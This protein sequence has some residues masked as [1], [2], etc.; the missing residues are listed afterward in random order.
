MG[1]LPGRTGTMRLDLDEFRQGWK[2]VVASFIGMA[3]SLMALAGTYSIGVLTGPLTREFGWS[4]GDVMLVPTLLY[5][6]LIPS[7]FVVGWI[8]DHYGVRKMTMFS[9]VALALGFAALGTL[10]QGGLTGF[11]AIYLLIGIFGEAAGPISYTRSIVGW[12]KRNRGFAL[13]LIMSG[14]GV[15]AI[16]IPAYTGWFVE[17]HGW[18]QAYLAL[19]VLPVCITLPAVWFLLKEVPGTAARRAGT[20]VPDPHGL[21]FTQ[22]IR[23]YRFWVM[24]AVFSVLTAI[25]ISVIT[26]LVPMLTDAGYDL[27]TAVWMGST[28]GV[29]TVI[30]RISFGFLLDR[31]WAP[32]VA[33]FVLLPA[34]AALIMLSNPHWGMSSTIL[35][36]ALIGLMNG[37][38]FDLLIYMM[39]RYFG[40]RSYGTLFALMYVLYNTAAAAG[41]AIYG[42]TFDAF[43]NYRPVLWVSAGLVV[44]S[45]AALFTLGKYPSLPGSQRQAT[46][47][48]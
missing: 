17:H 8:A 32:K 30:G 28:W 35:A 16:L 5:A 27:S 41:P 40:S 42:Y 38:E 34:A 10:S 44:L 29:A 24:V 48:G 20:Q 14:T 26:N 36:I 23:G 39:T 2:V 15:S 7:S 22:A 25:V 4:R 31:F 33:A 43:G 45:T 9:L 1:E 13:G 37:A 19:A 21:T 11:L 12:F 18:R 3:L 46:Q 47:N 6:G